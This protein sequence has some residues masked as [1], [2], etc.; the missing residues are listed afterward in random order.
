MYTPA[1][2]WRIVNVLARLFGVMNVG[3]GAAFTVNAVLFLR[4]PETAQNVSSIGGNASA[5]FAVVAVFCLTVGALF[6]A[7][8]PY[9]PDLQVGVRPLS[10]GASRKLSWLT[11]EPRT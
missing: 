7:V 4:H 9:R 6:L 5:E 2:H 11:G 10:D 3:V 8:K 1:T